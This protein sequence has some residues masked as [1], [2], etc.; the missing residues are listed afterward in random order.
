M[1]RLAVL[2]ALLLPA[3]A[4]AAP[5]E[6]GPGKLGVSHIGS[7]RPA[8]DPSPA[9]AIAAFGEPSSSKGDATAC[10][11]RWR[12][13]G[14]KV[15]F[16]DFGGGEDACTEGRAQSFRATG[17]F[18]TWRGLRVGARKRAILRKHPSADRHARSY[19]LKTAKSPFG[20]GSSYAVVRAI[21]GGGK[22][23]ALA[24][25]IGAAGE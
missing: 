20:E 23:T 25:W 13:L 8:E 19:W 15:V 6:I 12:D 21:V 17:A 5:L 14:L 9:G 3:S 22:V 2:A 7:F 10:T 4:V 11:V 24:G 18:T 16:A 1:K